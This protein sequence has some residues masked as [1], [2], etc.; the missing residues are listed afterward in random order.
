MQSGRSSVS[1]SMVF[2][3]IS[4]DFLGGQ[5]NRFSFFCL[6]ITSF[7]VMQFLKRFPSW[8]Q[9]ERLIS[10]VFAA[11]SLFVPRG[12][13]V[14]IYACS[15]SMRLLYLSTLEL[16]AFSFLPGRMTSGAYG[17]RSRSVWTLLETFIQINFD[18]TLIPYIRDSCFPLTSHP[19]PPHRYPRMMKLSG[20][21]KWTFLLCSCSLT[22]AGPVQVANLQLPATAAGNQTA[23][24]NIFLTS[25]NAYM[26]VS[27][28]SSL[29]SVIE[30]CMFYSTSAFGHDELLPESPPSFVDDLNGWGGT[31]ADALGTLVHSPSPQRSNNR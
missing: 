25:Y 4:G 10:Q 17:S 24:K 26:C 23:V 7:F 18:G 12:L 21:S 1:I 2:I 16:G 14:N 29:V 3:V 19:W 28:H 27:L 15:D 20:L 8:G 9:L 5:V 22:L 6:E 31:I 30:L 13:V 11:S